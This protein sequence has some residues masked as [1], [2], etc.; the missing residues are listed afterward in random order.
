MSESDA[1]LSRLMETWAQSISGQALPPLSEALST[2]LPGVWRA[3]DFVAQSCLRQPEMLTALDASGDL[4]RGYAAGEM[5]ARIADALTE[6][7]DEAALAA[8]LRR[9]RRREMVRIMWRDLTRWASLDET[10]EDLSALADA[11]IDGALDRLYEWQC[12]ASGVPRSADGEAQRMV[13]LGMGKLG[14][15]E[16]N[17]SS[18]IDLIFAYAENGETDGRRPLANE[19][20]FTRLGQKLNKALNSQTVDGFVFRVD[21]RLRPFGDA[22]PLATSF[23]FMESYYQS[24]AREWERYAMIK[25]R[26][27]AG[28]REAGAEL[29]AMLRPFVYRRYIDFG[30]I[31]SLRDMKRLINADL[32]RKGMDANIKLGPGGIREIEFIGQAFQLIRGGRDPALQIR[33]IQQVLKRLAEKDMIPPRDAEE[34][35][36]AYRF[37]R[38][39]ENRLQAWRDEQTQ[40]LPADDEGRARLALSMGFE[41][42][43]GFSAALEKHRARVQHHFEQLFADAGEERERE[44]PLAAVWLRPGSAKSCELL[45]GSGYDTPEPVAELIGKFHDSRPVRAMGGRGRERLDQLMPKALAAAGRA[46]S[47]QLVLE[48]L[49]AILE[50]VAGRTAYLDLMVENPSILEQLVRLG[51]ASPWFSAQI[52]RQPLLLDELVDPRE[53]YAPRHT[54]SLRA[55]LAELL[56]GVDEGDLEQEMERLRQFASTNRLRVAAADVTGVIPLV[57]VSDYLTDIAQVVLE[58]TLRL[59]WRDLTEKHGT[60]QGVDGED[61]GIAVIGY[62]KL[63]GIEL[64]YG[65]DLDLVFLHG[66]HDQGAMTD[67][68]RAVYNE[69]F[70]AR[71]G[72][73]LVHILTTRTPSGILYEADM[74]LRPNGNAGALVPAIE[75]FDNYQ[76]NEAWTWEHQALIRARFIAGDARVAARFE[77]TRRDV[78]GRP[79]EVAKLR[80]DVREMREKMRES[81]DKTTQD[82]FDLKQGRGGITDIE[83]MVQFCVLRW[84]HQYPDLLEWTDN[85]RLLDTLVRHD[86]L[87]GAAAVQLANMYRALRA[88]YH[89]NALRE[90]PGLIAADDL[91]EERALVTEMWQEMME[92]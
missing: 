58:Q 63:G 5:A 28:D 37:L 7:S 49:F 17:L 91:T 70:Y 2:T 30:V 66:D 20:F 21:M 41:D 80:A 67:G 31:K 78:L 62:G 60:P 75:T 47:P 3:S 45:V 54:D 61:S 55:E 44:S 57:V 82:H 11:C 71:L 51:D 34:L 39:T 38:D 65:S 32:H 1:R 18:D 36:T 81:L 26:V 29:M 46:Q 89:R 87:E 4:E 35:I 50:A 13:V 74:R 73:R 6:V 23:E 43:A 42:W 68:R 14:A 10:L 24:Q 72:Q 19:Q 88:A 48:R 27:V 79:H 77:A 56:R 76:H 16:L 8:A 15:R 85:I 40:R 90:E 92:A 59:A 25:A 9:I 53:L 22:G 69:V 84:A 12:A 33:P 52:A 64:G 83:F 86:L